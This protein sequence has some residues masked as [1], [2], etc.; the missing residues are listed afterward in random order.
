MIGMVLLWHSSLLSS[1]LSAALWSFHLYFSIYFWL[2]SLPCWLFRVNVW[3]MEIKWNKVTF[4][5]QWAILHSWKILEKRR[6]LVLWFCWGSPF[7]YKLRWNCQHSSLF[8]IRT[9]QKSLLTSLCWKKVGWV[10]SG[11][12]IV[13]FT[14]S[15]YKFLGTISKCTLLHI[16]ENFAVQ[17]LSRPRT[18]LVQLLPSAHQS[19]LLSGTFWRIPC[20]NRG[21]EWERRV[22]L[23]IEPQGFGV[24]EAR[25]VKRL[26]WKQLEFKD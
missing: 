1:W 10:M 20:R 11:R 5:I 3:R 6:K 14:F 25:L 8:W 21:F 17:Y 4:T 18:G 15:G 16:L 19:Q 24:S 12:H 26:A 9:D 7:P 22:F 2:E 23:S 13:Q